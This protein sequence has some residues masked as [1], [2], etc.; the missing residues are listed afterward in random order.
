M[1]EGRHLLILATVVHK[2]HAP[3]PA[4]IA[5]GEVQYDSPQPLVRA[6][7]LRLRSERQT[8][9]R[10]PRTG[11]ILFTVRTSVIPSACKS[12]RTDAAFGLGISH[13]MLK[14]HSIS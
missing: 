13:R 8:L 4:A 14:D 12:L 1:K 2:L 6:E 5:A 9:R 11:A 3:D 10:M 7:D